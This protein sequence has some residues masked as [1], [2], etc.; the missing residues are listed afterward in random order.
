[1]LSAVRAMAQFYG[2]SSTQS[3]DVTQIVQL[4]RTTINEFII[5]NYKN[6]SNKRTIALYQ[7]KG[8]QSPK[9]QYKNV[10]KS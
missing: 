10:P 3:C 6:A 7:K 1:M 2:L 5:F 8:K 4:P 9:L